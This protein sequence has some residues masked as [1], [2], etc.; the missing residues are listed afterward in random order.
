MAAVTSRR[1]AVIAVHG[2]ADQRPGESAAAIGAMLLGIRDEEAGGSV[3]EPFQARTIHVPLA[4]VVAQAVSA[5]LSRAALEAGDYNRTGVWDRLTS[6]FRESQMG[7]RAILSEASGGE[8]AALEEASDATVG[9]QSASNVDAGLT[10]MRLLLGRY[11][12]DQGARSYITTRLEGKRPGRGE[13]A[14]SD[15]KEVDVYELHWADLSTLGRDPLRFFASLYQLV[16]HLSELGRG[17][18]EDGLREFGQ[19][20]HWVRLVGLH[21]FAVRQLAVPI[22]I[23]NLILLLAMTGAV[24]VRVVGGSA[25]DPGAP[26][27]DIANNAG[28]RVGAVAG[29]VAIFIAVGYWIA[30]PPHRP[31]LRGWWVVPLLSGIVGA[32]IGVGF[33]RFAGRADVVLAVECWLAAYLLLAFILGKY[34][35]VRPGALKSGKLLYF[36]A[37]VTFTLALIVGLALPQSNAR[38]VEYA[39][40]WTMQMM[41]LLL[42]AFWALLILTGF[43]GAVYGHLIVRSLRGAPR[44]RARAAIRTSRLALGISASSMIG[45]LV[46]AWSGLLAWGVTSVNVFECMETRSFPSLP[47]ANSLVTPP[48][49]LMRWLQD[50][51][52]PTTCAGVKY[53]VHGYFRAVLLMTTTSGLP[54]SLLLVGLSLLLLVWMAM[55]SVRLEGETPGTCKNVDSY[56][57][58]AWLSRGLDTTKVVTHLWWA[59]VF[60]I[61]PLFWAGDFALRHGW[62]IVEPLE[63]VL[64]ISRRLALPILQTGGS[65]I[66]ASA[67]VIFFGIAKLGGS[68]LDVLLDVDNYLRELPRTATPRARI[69]ERYAS[70]LRFVG[71][72]RTSDGRPYD[73]VVIVAHSLGALISA[74]LLRFFVSESAASR[75]DP[76]LAPFGMGATQSPATIPIHLFTMGNPLRQLLNRFF[77]HQYFWVRPEPDNAMRATA[78]GAASASMPTELSPVPSDLGLETWSNAYRSGDYVG[79]SLWLDEWYSRTRS[80]AADAGPYP[81]PIHIAK[82]NKSSEMCIGLGAHTHYWDNTAPDIRDHIDRLIKGA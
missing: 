22:P 42:S 70:L 72:A 75:G 10:Y 11:K 6:E 8:M 43:C 46:I 58:G 78:A 34:E 51:P 63:S 73:A 35:R 14:D 24:L 30:A 7:Y 26:S 38:A 66:A 4:P 81:E 60:V 15:A 39:T 21:A 2:V 53:S 45:I 28:V 19:N 69:A 41:F 36:I 50:W 65:L 29:A 47:Y 17:A 23:L 3:Y 25:I 55:P 9:Q 56:R 54:V 79:R 37:G 32:I 64:R 62:E 61:L 71:A 48:A 5:D 18:L 52:D 80:G 57:V 49:D 33:D 31:I 40:L 77:P 27:F 13:A 68:A 44:A 16:L 74:D 12:G 82:E 59:S 20:K 67:A 1:I 76:Q